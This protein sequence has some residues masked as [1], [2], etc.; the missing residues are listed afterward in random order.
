MILLLAAVVSCCL[1]DVSFADFC[2]L[3]PACWQRRTTRV[4]VVRSTYVR[5]LN[6][7]KKILQLFF[8]SQCSSFLLINTNYSI[9]KMKTYC[10]CFFFVDDILQTLEFLQFVII[11]TRIL[12]LISI[13]LPSALYIFVVLNTVFFFP[14]FF[15]SWFSCRCFGV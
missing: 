1:P 14:C 13:F 11:Q 4:Y 3:L 10:Y 9:E 8:S 15:F 2:L 7:T 5:T 12:Y 6:E